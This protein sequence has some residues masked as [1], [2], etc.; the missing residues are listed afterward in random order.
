MGAGDLH[1]ERLR[2]QPEAAAHVAGLL[3]LIAG[4]VLAPP[5]IV[6]FAEAALEVAD[7]I[8]KGQVGSASGHVTCNWP[9]TRF[10]TS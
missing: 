1:G 7:H 3:R 4:Q 10:A 8:R 2:L 9:K 5:R 6:A